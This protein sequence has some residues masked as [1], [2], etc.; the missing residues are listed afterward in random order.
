MT[1]HDGATAGHGATRAPGAPAGG[2]LDPEP[3]RERVSAFVR[4]RVFP[5]EAVLDAGGPAAAEARR[6][7]RARAR[8]AGLWE[9]GRAHV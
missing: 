5:E 7:L 4:D 3:L 1:D 8:A 9:I 2:G 6:R